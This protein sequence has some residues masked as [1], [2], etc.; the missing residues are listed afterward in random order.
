MPDRGFELV[1][2]VDIERRPDAVFAFLI[3]DAGIRALDRALIDYGPP[4]PWQAGTSGWLRHRRG[5]MTAQ[6]TFRVTEFDA[7]RRL[8]VLVEG[9]GYGMTESASLEATATGT[10]ARFVDRVWPTSLPGRLLVA[11]SSGIMRRDL[12]KRSTLLKSLMEAT[13]PRP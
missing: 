4:G 2:Q 10:R 5:R 12:A 7:P 3:D 9:M 1:H 8:E 11:L 6:T 13:T